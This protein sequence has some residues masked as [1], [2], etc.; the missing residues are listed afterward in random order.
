MP[1]EYEVGLLIKWESPDRVTELT[2]EFLEWTFS[3]CLE[4]H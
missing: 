4:I 1:Y 3:A 2:D